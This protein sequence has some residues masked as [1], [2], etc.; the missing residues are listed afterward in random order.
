MIAI[1]IDIGMTGAIA[2]VDSR[3]SAAVHDLPLVEGEDRRLCGRQLILLVRQLV[4]PGESAVVAYEDVRVRQMGG[5]AMSHATEGNLVR[6][7]GIVECVVDIS[8]LQPVVVQPQTWKRFYGLNKKDD[9]KEMARLIAA[10]LFPGT[11]HELQRKKDHNRAESL[12]IANY[13]LRKVA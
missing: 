8:R 3:G 13:A 6:C 11:A 2:A 10:E 4:R 9:A 12:L 7:R 5:R 1:G